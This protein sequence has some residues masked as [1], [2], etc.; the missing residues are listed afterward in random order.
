MTR[1]ARTAAAVLA[2]LLL[3]GCSSGGGSTSSASGGSAPL[4]IGVMLPLS[5]ADRRG[6]ED[7]L[8]WAVDNVNKAGGVAGRKLEL[9]YADLDKTSLADATHRF[10][11]DRDIVAVIGPNSSD[12]VFAA[13][14]AFITAK[15]TLVSPTATSGDIFR[16]F[17]SSGFVWRTVQSDITQVRTALLL[18]AR[19]GARRPAIVAGT[20]HYGSTFYDWFG[21]YA[22]ELGLQPSAVVRYDQSSQ[23][24]TPSVDQALAAHPDAMLAAAKDEANAECMAKAW[25]AKGS[26]GR[27]LFTDA[28]EANGLIEHLGHD[29]EGLEGLGLGPDPTNGFVDAFRTRF[30]H[31]PADAATNSYD[32]V[33]LL[34]YGL[35]RSGGVGG[36]RLNKAMADVVDARGAPTSWDAPGVAA[37]LAA[38]K[39]G[40]L[41]DVSGATGPLDFDATTHTDLLSSTYEHWRVEGGAFKTVDLLPSGPAQPGKSDARV[42]PLESLQAN[43]RAATGPPYQPPAPKAGVWAL[44]VATS[45]GWD[46][47][48]HQADVFA[49]YQMLRAGG[50]PAD[51]IIVV[52]ADDLAQD[53]HNKRPGQVPYR[54]GGPDVR[55]GVHIDYRLDQVNA[56]DLLSILAGRRSAAL[57]K[58][59]DSSS[60]DNVYVFIAGHGDTD[61]VYVGLNQPVVH[62]GDKYSILRPADLA[63]TVSAMSKAG[64][65]R[66][67]LLAVEA[68]KGGVMGSGLNAPGAFLVSAASPAENSLSANYDDQGGTWLADQFAATLERTERSA[69]QTDVPLGSALGQIYLN[70]SG[71]HVSSYGSGFGD[72]HAVGLREFVTP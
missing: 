27:L 64:R 71:S 38:I 48:R 49:Q 47:Y 16:A 50:V 69:Q 65:Y 31:D 58:V 67:M 59:V 18:M 7:P 13:A 20:G 17:S 35:Q 51:R 6:Y 9:V 45:G 25:R 26:P 37:A 8:G 11:S 72:P 41:P 42:T 55:E 33:T 1:A 14:P 22:G 44:L 23:D 70:V 54:V 61:G 32:A 21:F 53:G 15:K 29:A 4:R 5:G 12:R 10:V 40:Q 43:Y 39:S 57:P 28:A 34:A 62:E 52:A 68:C 66:R 2:V 46:N 60:A 63:S 30:G 56:G 3:A 36:E 24:C 19:D